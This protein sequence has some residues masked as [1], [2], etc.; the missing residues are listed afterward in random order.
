MDEYI[1]IARQVLRAGAWPE[2]K[3][4]GTV[5][6]DYQGRQ[7]RRRRLVTEDG[8]AFVLD[9]AEPMQLADGDALVLE[10]GALI[11]VAAERESLLHIHTHDQMTLLRIIWHLGNRHLPV[12]I[13]GGGLR[14]PADHVIARMVEKLGAHVQVIQAVFTPEAGAYALEGAAQNHAAHTHHEEGHQQEFHRDD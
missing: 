4:S 12:E 13:V 9:L 11:R 8:R 5:R 6:L 3:M 1:P 2:G 7:R 10:H 14:T